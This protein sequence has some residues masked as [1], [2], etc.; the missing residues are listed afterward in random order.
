MDVS[1]DGGR[2]PFDTLANPFPNGLVQ[3]TGSR[4]GAATGIGGA[5]DGQ[6]FGVR[7][8]YTEQWNLTVQHQP[9][10]T[11]LFE[12]A[13]IGNHGV[14]A[15]GTGRQLNFPSEQTLSLGRALADAVPNPFRGLI[16]S[17][18]L[19][20][21]TITRLQSLLPF[22][23]FGVANSVNSV[24]G[25]YFFHLNSIYH[26]LAVKAEK[27]FSQGLTMIGAYT[28]S[29]LI[30]DGT[31]AG[32]IRP[33]GVASTAIQ[34]WNNLRAE[35]SKSV[36]D[37]PQRLVLT[38]VYELPLFQNGARLTKAVLGGWQVN[39]ILTVESGTPIAL[40]A[41]GISGIGTRP[42]VNPGVAYK[43]DKPSVNR[44]FNGAA[45]SAPAPYT[46]G[47]L[48]RTLPD[49]HSDGLFSLDFSLFKRF[50]V[51]ERHKIEFRAE[52]FNLTN[53]PTFDTPDRSVTSQTFGVVTATAFSPKPREVQ[54]AL[55]LVF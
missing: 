2:T 23:Q 44:W 45:F 51:T 54:L 35:R 37:L 41:P 42:S 19:S 20:G 43:I 50:A 47:N 49:L 32:A 12:A 25:G 39:G 15:L 14:H 53:S 9:W 27:R 55:R 24:G 1:R 18:T 48:S 26:A 28:L 46:F 8:G 29:K 52:A 11:W 40:A 5:V 10:S 13:W 38:T 16:P 3:P 33:G 17:G 7:R 4:L 6:I 22:P 36:Q 34:N 31:G 30:D 21:A